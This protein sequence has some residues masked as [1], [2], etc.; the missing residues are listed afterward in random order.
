GFNNDRPFNCEL[1]F[2]ES[3]REAIKDQAFKLALVEKDFPRRLKNV[4]RLYIQ[5]MQV[6][7]GRDPKPTVILCC[8]PQEV[9]DTC[10]VQEHR[11]RLRRVKQPKSKASKAQFSLFEEATLGIEEEE[12]GHQN[13]RRGLK[14]E[15]ME[16]GIPT[17]LVWP[18]TL[19]LSASGA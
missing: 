1:I 17:Q 14:A 4:I 9:I 18:K 2:G 12:L 16:V 11:F 15:A 3:L 10:T 5:A 8:I 6:L 13:L 19:R 7:K